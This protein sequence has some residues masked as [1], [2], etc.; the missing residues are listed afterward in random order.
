MLILSSIIITDMA[1][2]SIL[3]SYSFQ[4][5]TNKLLLITISII[6]LN[7]GAQDTGSQ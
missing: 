3:L 2:T 6:L 7:C 5:Y 1:N 4:K